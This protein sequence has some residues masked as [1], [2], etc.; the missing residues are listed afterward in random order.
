MYHHTEEGDR[1]AT[2]FRCSTSLSIDLEAAD[3]AYIQVSFPNNEGQRRRSTLV[4]IGSLTIGGGGEGDELA[5]VLRRLAERI[6]R[7]QTAGEKAY[8]SR[9]AGTN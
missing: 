5:E 1:E 4:Q 7:T 8:R 9:E 3:H 2:Q 6:E